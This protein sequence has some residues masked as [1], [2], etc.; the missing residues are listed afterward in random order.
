[1]AE[2]LILHIGAAKTGTSAIQSALARNRDA[3]AARGLLVPLGRRA[4]KARS[5]RVTGGNARL[6]RVFKSD[7]PKDRQQALRRLE[8][9]V[10]EILAGNSCY[11]VLLSSERLG[12]FEPEVIADMKSVLDGH[13]LHYQIVYYVRHLTDHAISQYNERVKR[14][15]MTQSFKAFAPSY[16]S[17]FKQALETYEPLFGRENVVC[18]LYDDVWTDIFEDFLETIGISPEGLEKPEQ[19]NRSLTADEIEVL[20]AINAKKFDKIQTARVVEDHVYRHEPI[21]R[22]Y[23]EFTRAEIEV[24]GANNRD[25]ID[26]VNQRLEGQSRLKAAS[27]AV[28][29]AARSVAED[30]DKGIDPEA[31]LALLEASL[32]VANKRIEE[33]KAEK[34]EEIKALLESG[35]AQETPPAEPSPLTALVQPV[36]RA[37][38]PVKRAVRAVLKK[39]W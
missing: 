13:F 33:V 37:V 10:E 1:M 8:D 38:R 19:V 28:L 23:P 34:E 25:V 15:G 35:P 9:N 2:K 7:L 32:R 14:R 3:L 26:F 17:P 36:K 29:S 31:T 12:A 21:G 27:D 16:V 20:R 18:R 39:G 11:M 22:R 30:T 4:K 24:I 5:G 6:F